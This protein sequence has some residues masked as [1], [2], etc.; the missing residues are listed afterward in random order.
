MASSSTDAPSASSCRMAAALAANLA[1]PSLWGQFRRTFGIVGLPVAPLLYVFAAVGW[2]RL[3][4]SWSSKRV[5]VVVGLLALLIAAQTCQTLAWYP[6]Y[7]I[8]FNKVSGGV[9]GALARRQGFNFVGQNAAIEFL[10]EKAKAADQLQYVTVFGDG[11]LMLKQLRRRYPQVRADF[12]FYDL[13][14]ADFAVAFLS[15]AYLWPGGKWREI[16]GSEP[17][18]TYAVDAQPLLKIFSLPWPKYEEKVGVS[19]ANAARRTG[20]LEKRHGQVMA[21]AL[22]KRD[23]PGEIFFAAGWRVPAGEFVFTALL[24]R[25]KNRHSGDAG[26]AVAKLS[27]GPGCERSISAAELPPGQTVPVELR[28]RFEDAR[29]RVPELFWF[30]D[31]PLGVKSVTLRRA[32]A[33]PSAASK[34]KGLEEQVGYPANHLKSP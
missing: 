18:F 5:G 31:S 13:N 14:T 20:A 24:R 29:R 1:F 16:L 19:A 9:K 15:H 27:F 3:I 23:K 33:E 25:F 21:V 2:C 32:A 4:L 12:G 22:P 8:F 34:K 11:D 28:C 6:H 30:G 17:V 10:A 26:G 7:T